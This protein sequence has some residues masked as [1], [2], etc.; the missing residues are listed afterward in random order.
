MAMVWFGSG[1]KRHPDNNSYIPTQRRINKS[2]FNEEGLSLLGFV[3]R[4]M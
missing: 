1:S 3:S 4:Y 2:N